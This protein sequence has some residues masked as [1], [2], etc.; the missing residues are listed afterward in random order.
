MEDTL[1]LLKIA[2][3]ADSELSRFGQVGLTWQGRLMT[4]AILSFLYFKQ[5]R[6]MDSLKFLYK[7]HTLVQE[8]KDT[9]LLVHGHIRNLLNLLTFLVLWK[10]QKFHECEK[11]LDTMIEP[12]LGS[13]RGRNLFGLVCT[14]KAAVLCKKGKDFLLAAQICQQALEKL[15]KDDIC[16]D[17]LKDAID[18][19]FQ[20]IKKTKED[21]L[22]D[23][24]FLTV[25]FVT[26]F[27]PLIAP[28][29]PVLKMS[30]LTKEPRITASTSRTKHVWANN[31]KIEIDEPLTTRRGKNTFSKGKLQNQSFNLPYSSIQKAYLN[32]AGKL[33]FLSPRVSNVKRP[34]SSKVNVKRKLLYGV[35]RK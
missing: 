9:G 5:S 22:V 34:K 24:N 6:Y 21:W 25:F 16:V 11:Y 4:P 27:I 29:T 12:D 33:N 35:D 32:A 17:L 1:S 7:S 8:I 26:C 20:E 31:L 2:D 28:G 3:K 19:I 23:K 14:S 10:L 15:E 18:S 13:I 30:T